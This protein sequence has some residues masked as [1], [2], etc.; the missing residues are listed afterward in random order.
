MHFA[1]FN[2]TRVLYGVNIKLFWFQ[3]H[4]FILQ[5]VQ[6]PTIRCVMEC[7]LKK[8]V[9]KAEDCLVKGKCSLRMWWRSAWNRTSELSIEREV[10]EHIPLDMAWVSEEVSEWVIESQWP[11]VL[12]ER[13][14]IQLTP[15]L[16][17]TVRSYFNSGFNNATGSDFHGEQRTKIS[18]RCRIS[19]ERIKIPVRGTYCN[20]IQ[21]TMAYN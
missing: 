19:L 12:I 17:F 9:K 4:Y 20:H 13:F 16:F 15:I 6:R 10:C 2:L 14:R 5:L 21:V 11:N 3:S 8:R 7:I 18:L 1:C